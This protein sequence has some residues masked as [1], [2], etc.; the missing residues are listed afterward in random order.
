MIETR[1][2]VLKDFHNSFGLSMFTVNFVLKNWIFFCLIDFWFYIL[3]QYEIHSLSKDLIFLI[4]EIFLI[5]CPYKYL[6]SDCLTRVQYFSYCTDH[7]VQKVAKGG[8][9]GL[10]SKIGDCVI[11]VLSTKLTHNW[12]WGFIPPFLLFDIALFWSFAYPLASNDL[13]PP[14]TFM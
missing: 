6:H 1:P 7:R 9:G 14:V 3:S 2:R 10:S 5:V 11:L 4:F 12:Q 8:G 13:C